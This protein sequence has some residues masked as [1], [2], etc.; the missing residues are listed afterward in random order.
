MYVN[1]LEHQY[2]GIAFSPTIAAIH[3]F[4]TTIFGLFLISMM[5]IEIVTNFFGERDKFSNNSLYAHFW[6]DNKTIDGFRIVFQ[7]FPPGPTAGANTTLLNFSV[8]D[9]ENININNIFSALIIKEKDSNLTV[10]QIP[11]RRY[12]FSDF[13]IPYVFDNNTEYVVT[14]ETRIMG[15]PKYQ[16]EPIIASFDLSVGDLT[17][18]TFRNIM[19]Y[20]VTPASLAVSIICLLILFWKKKTYRK[21]V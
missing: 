10:E 4:T 15:D 8:L 19:L 1:I 9:E 20:Y 18:I 7:P 11:Y 21:Q 2:T 6:G 12:E 13:S 5:V 14:L 16:A 17:Y 3:F